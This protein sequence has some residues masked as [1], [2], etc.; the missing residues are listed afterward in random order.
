VVLFD[1]ICNI[2]FADN[3]CGGEVKLS[4]LLAQ[5]CLFFLLRIVLVRLMLVP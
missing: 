1:E 4:S 5:V 3:V 2:A